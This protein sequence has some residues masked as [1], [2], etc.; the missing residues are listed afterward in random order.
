M[1]ILSYKN[2]LPLSS[3]KPNTGYSWGVEFR[4]QKRMQFT[5]LL[6]QYWVPV[7][8][9]QTRWGIQDFEFGSPNLPS[10]SK[11]HS[12]GLPGGL[13]GVGILALCT[14]T[15]R[16]CSAVTVFMHFGHVWYQEPCLSIFKHSL[17][18]FKL[19]KQ[20]ARLYTQLWPGESIPNEMLTK[21][22]GM[23]QSYYYLKY[24]SP[25]GSF[26]VL[27]YSNKIWQVEEKGEI[28]K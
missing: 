20:K 14:A 1:C 2:H 24:N 11:M 15:S 10:H 13:R 18:M 23:G 19:K 16:S 3:W 28:R 6:H 12:P 27:S 26:A 5:P 9:K 25:S 4:G 17:Y 8:P 7:N 22:T 21:E